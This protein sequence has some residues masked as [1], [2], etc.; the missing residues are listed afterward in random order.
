MKVY[1]RFGIPCPQGLIGMEVEVEGNNLPREIPSY[2]KVET[3]NSLR[4]EAKEYILKRPFDPKSV[5][6]A[7]DIL[8][9]ATANSELH[10]SHRTS[11]H[12]HINVCSL[13]RNQLINF[14]FISYFFDKT[15]SRFGGREIKGNRFALRISD[16]EGQLQL[17]SK[18][19]CKKESWFVPD[20]QSGKYA[21][22][23]LAPIGKYGSVEFR[24]MRGTLDPVVLKK[25][26]SMIVSLYNFSLKFSTIKDMMYGFIDN[27]IEFTKKVFGTLADNFSQEH[28]VNDLRFNY[29]LLLD[30]MFG[31][32]YSEEAKQEVNAPPHGEIKYEKVMM[33][34]RQHHLVVNA[35]RPNDV[36]FAGEYLINREAFIHNI[37]VG[38]VP[39]NYRRIDAFKQ[40]FNVIMD[41]VGPEEDNRI[42]END[43][44]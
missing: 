34:D 9:K 17:F 2:W 28:I 13:T 29:S 23:N 31:V 20:I 10:F 35:P 8:V 33:P 19:A 22:I 32:E 37:A 39:E 3:D 11:V 30:I 14:L 16:A 15:L 21:A 6:K 1:E 7:I 5:S 24:S 12:V 27:E 38:P 36:N 43:P 26:V 42:I 40:Q 18:L 41:E 25:W 4:G 44:F